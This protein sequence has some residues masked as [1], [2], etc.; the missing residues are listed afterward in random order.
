DAYRH[1]DWNADCH[2]DAHAHAYR[3]A[4]GADAH[5]HP[6][7]HRDAGC[8]ADPYRHVDANGDADRTACSGDPP[9]SDTD[10]DTD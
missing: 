8:A 9:H 7:A 10:C 4:R 3:D 1:P 2:T 5:A 6:D